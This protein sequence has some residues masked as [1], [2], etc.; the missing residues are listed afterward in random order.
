[1]GHEVD[2]G[3]SPG[4]ARAALARAW[5]ASFGPATL[6]D[7]KWWTGWTMGDTRRAVAAVDPVEVALDDGGIGLVLRDDVETTARPE[8]WVALL[9]ALDPTIMGW[10]GRD[11]YIGGRTA[12]VFDRAGNASPTVWADGRVVGGWALTDDGEVVVGLFEDIGAEAGAAVSAE[13]ASLTSWFSDRTRPRFRTE[14]EREVLA[15]NIVPR[16][17]PRGV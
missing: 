13:A 16:K 1:V 6:T 10:T 5:L 4:E 2:D 7:L 3:R 15:G 9:P 8:P 11:W 14:L 12:A 17:F